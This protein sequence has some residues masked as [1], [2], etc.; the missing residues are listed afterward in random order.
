MVAGRLIILFLL[1]Q[2]N[3]T[4]FSQ[5]M[6]F[7]EVD[8]TT[9]AMY[10]END[11]KGLI[12]Y[13]KQS[14]WQGIDYYYLRM[15]L[16]LAF[17]ETQN[18][19]LASKQ[20]EKA[21]G[22]NS[23]SNDAWELWYR[24]L[25]LSG[26]HDLKDALEKKMPEPRR[27]KIAKAKN[28]FLEMVYMEGGV[29]ANNNF[30]KNSS[31]NIMGKDKLYGEQLLYGNGIYGHAGIR[32]R[33]SGN[34]KL[35]LG[36]N[37]L[38][39]EVKKKF[40]Y[41]TFSAVPNSA[42]V[43]SWGYSK[44][45]DFPVESNERIFQYKVKQNEVYSNLTYTFRNGLQIVPAF[46]WSQ[47]NFK[48]VQARYE[49]ET[50]S[51]TAIFIN[52]GQLTGWFSYNRPLYIFTEENVNT[53]DYLFSL[54][55]NQPFSVFEAG[56]SAAWSK[57]DQMEFYQFDG[58]LY[59][60]PFGNLDFYGL[61]ELRYFK[62][63]WDDRLIYNQ[64]LGLKIA[65]WLWTE[66]GY[67]HGDLSFTSE[68]YGLTIFSTTDEIKY[69]ISGRLIFPVN[70]HITLNLRYQLLERKG[71]YSEARATDPRTYVIKEF[72]YQQQNIIGGIQW[73]F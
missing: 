68:N 22:Y 34:L 51:D 20:F 59:Y 58:R 56:I 49:T 4:A 24:S 57:Y 35:Y 15:R 27:D 55:L 50:A 64:M 53:N 21:V 25:E 71:L 3:L 67:T 52:E 12:H 62:A 23:A 19:F 39:T 31:V 60:Y 47:L 32:L 36:Y 45:Y 40:Q 46:H 43:E 66:A 61:S 13:G 54:S 6:N 9:F 37:F 17:M 63:N 29:L 38:D 48:V 69:R 2:I 18:Y 8:S 73:S 70:K 44:W 16:G 1:F 26:R 65:S 11:W 10:N 14:L 33:V 41:T 30:D 72:D 28:T 7:R 42:V 5:K